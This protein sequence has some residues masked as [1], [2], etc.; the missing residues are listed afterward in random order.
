MSIKSTIADNVVKAASRNGGKAAIR[1]AAKKTADKAAKT[2]A[3]DSS[4]AAGAKLSPAIEQMVQMAKMAAK[5]GN[6]D[7]SEK[8]FVSAGQAAMGV[9]TASEQNLMEAIRVAQIA[10]HAEGSGNAASRILVG[11]KDKFTDFGSR[12]RLADA[13]DNLKLK[14]LHLDLSRGLAAYAPTTG[15]AVKIAGNLA[16]TAKTQA[17][18]QPLVPVALNTG[19]RRAQSLA[20]VQAIQMAALQH[21]ADGAFADATAVSDRLVEQGHVGAGNYSPQI[22]EVLRELGR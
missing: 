17:A 22:A 9:G 16:T 2:F 1:Q 19:L 20:D 3:A 4:A 7:A 11:A 8:A 10:N 5:T 13:A 6:S 21:G 15:D 18:F 12:V 14:D